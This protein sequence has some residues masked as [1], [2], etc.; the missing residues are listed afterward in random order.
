MESNRDSLPCRKRPVR[1]GAVLAALRGFAERRP[2]R[3]L[4]L[5]ILVVLIAVAL[6]AAYWP[7]HDFPGA[8]WHS[9]PR[10][11]DIEIAQAK[12][13]QA[14]WRELLGYWVGRTIH[15]HAYY[16]PLTSW[17]FVGEYRLFGRNDRLWASVNIA[18]HL[19]VA[20]ALVWVATT[21]LGGSALRRIGV[22]TL[23]ALLLGAP[24]LADRSIQSWILGWWPCQSE[25]A[26]LLFGL[27][28]L[29]TVALHVRTGE[30]RCAR[31]A[32]G[33]FLLS[34][35]FKEM[36]YVAGL[37]ACLLLLRQRKHWRQLAALAA[38]GLIL[39]G[40]RAFVLGGG[41]FLGGAYDPGRVA[42]AALGELRLPAFFARSAAIHAAALLPA[43]ALAGWLRR[44][45]A[46]AF[47]WIAALC[48]YGVL[49]GSV[50]GPPWEPTFQAAPL[51]ALRI[52]GWGALLY[53]LFRAGREWPVPELIGIWALCAAIGYGYPPIFGWYRYWA[54]VFGALL[55]AI[56]LAALLAPLS[57]RL[58]APRS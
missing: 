22:G 20:A 25:E 26:S 43:A 41:I 33:W 12:A 30:P 16:R 9:T 28:L 3:A 19:G 42:Q 31:W 50:L 10:G 8:M 35:A 51:E 5:A 18:L 57:R 49:A 32:P 27:L 11:D 54:S 44:R 29:G 24:G 48:L 21:L 46:G 2:R 17:L 4:A 58:A 38:C 6:E 56:A 15:G 14:G 45:G 47:A 52:A 36:G 37:G 53:G 23:A 13:A 34:V 39:F 55:T 7:L 40:F 1:P